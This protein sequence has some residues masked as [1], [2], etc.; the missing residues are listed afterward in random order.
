MR[1]NTDLSLLI[2][3]Q[4]NGIELVDD[5]FRRVVFLYLAVEIEAHHVACVNLAR[6]LEELDETLSLG[7]LHVSLTESHYEVHIDVVMVLFIVLELTSPQDHREVRRAET[8]TLTG[9]SFF[10]PIMASSS[11]L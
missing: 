7:L 4:T 9:P 6:Q 11:T 10:S 5:L 1:K 8:L 2:P 3:C